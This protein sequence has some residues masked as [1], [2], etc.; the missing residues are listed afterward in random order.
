MWY[1]QDVTLRCCD[2]G[3]ILCILLVCVKS[4]GFE[5]L[6]SLV[7]DTNMK[8]RAWC[9]ETMEGHAQGGDRRP[10][11]YAKLGLF[12]EIG[13]C[14]VLGTCR[15]LCFEVCCGSKTTYRDFERSSLVEDKEPSHLDC[16]MP[17]IILTI[18]W[19][20]S[21]PYSMSITIAGR[22]SS[23]MIPWGGHNLCISSLSYIRLKWFSLIVT[24]GSAPS[25]NPRGRAGGISQWV[26][27]K[28]VTLK[29]I[30]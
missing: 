3:M 28:D 2:E 8:I 30:G 10:A 24:T 12:W 25:Y 14:V 19:F 18:T 11:S 29:L 26:A 15:G 20:F 6:L 5:T 23:G 9:M 22:K 27:M 4:F 17:A 16:M 21:W 1:L 13:D 7:G